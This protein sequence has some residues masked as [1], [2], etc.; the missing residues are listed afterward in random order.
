ML[1][2]CFLMYRAIVSNNLLLSQ[3]IS[4]QSTIRKL[5]NNDIQEKTSHNENPSIV[6]SGLSRTVDYQEF[7]ANEIKNVVREELG[8]FTSKNGES[9]SK[10]NLTDQKNTLIENDEAYITCMTYIDTV[11]QNQRLTEEDTV[12]M[13]ANMRK[14]NGKQR[15][16]VVAKLFRGINTGEISVEDPSIVKSLLRKS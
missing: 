8:A 10:E 1:T 5:I 4:E 7:I 14:L 12:A 3:V 13:K 2:V 11:Y 6:V 9:T 15:T 16:E